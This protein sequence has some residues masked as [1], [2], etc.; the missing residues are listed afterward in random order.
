MVHCRAGHAHTCSS[1]NTHSC[2]ACSTLH[3]L[4]VCFIRTYPVSLRST[5]FRMVC[6][7]LS[8][9]CHMYML[10]CLLP[11][12]LP[13]QQCCKCRLR[14]LHNLFVSSCASGY[15]VAAAVHAKYCIL[16]TPAQ[17]NSTVSGTCTHMDIS[18]DVLLDPNRCSTSS[19]EGVVALSSSS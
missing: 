16:A 15:S 4:H 7:H 14:C 13:A 9:N 6:E 17:H 5:P 11:Y 19:A 3:A 10:L 2:V 8:I 1:V 12:Q 18:A